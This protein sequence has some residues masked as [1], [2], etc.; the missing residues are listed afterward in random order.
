MKTPISV[1]FIN[2]LMEQRAI[3]N[4][5]DIQEIAFVENGKELALPDGLVDDW[6]FSGLDNVG[7]ITSGRY[8]EIP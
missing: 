4:R 8:K 2:G 6:K 7:F 3:I 1:E 5:L